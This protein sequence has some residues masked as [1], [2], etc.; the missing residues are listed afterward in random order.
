MLNILQNVVKPNIIRFEH[1][2]ILDDEGLNVIEQY[3]DRQLFEQWQEEFVWIIGIILEDKGLNII[4]QYR[5]VGISY[6]SGKN[7]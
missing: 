4:E 7:G 6:H 2:D 3:M 1:C 5:L